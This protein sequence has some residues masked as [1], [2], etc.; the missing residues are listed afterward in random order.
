MNKREL[1]TILRHATHC[2]IQHDGWPC[3]TCFGAYLSR[4]NIPEDK[5][6]PYWQAVLRYRGDYND[7]DFQVDDSILKQNLKEFKDALSKVTV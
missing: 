7:F 1:K 2:T 6:N 3:G 4:L 5:H